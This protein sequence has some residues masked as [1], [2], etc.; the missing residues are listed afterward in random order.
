MIYDL[1]II[2]A[3]PGG[4]SAAG[5]A[6]GLG[7]KTALVEND[8][9]GGTCL[10]RGCV[11]TKLMLGAT[12]A[13]DELGAQAKVRVAE[14]QINIDFPALAKRKNKL[15]SATR[16][17]MSARL[18][19][20]GVDVFQGKG[21]LAGANTVLVESPAENAKLEFK[22]LILATGTSPAAFPGLSPD[23][24]NVLDS[25]G[26]LELEEM[27]TSLIVV[28][29]GFIGIEMAQAAHRMGTK[30]HIVDALERMAPAEDP[31]V[32]KTLQSVFKRRKWDIR[33]G[34]RVQSVSSEDNKAKMVLE[35]G[36]EI[37]A[38]KALIAVGR[39]PNTEGIGLNRFGIK[40]FG[41]GYIETD[42]YLKAADN[43]FAIGD[44]N[45]EVLLA[46]AADDQAR[47]AVNFIAGRI[48]GE[49]APGPVPSVLYGS[50]E[51]MRVGRL[52]SELE[53]GEIKAAKVALAA[54]PIAQAH[55]DTQGFVKVVCQDGVIKG[56]TAV[57][58]DV[59]RM[60]VAATMMVQ[61]GWSREKAMEFI[62]PHPTLDESMLQA[63]T[64]I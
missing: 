53:G 52:E 46:H 42:E 4:Y 64:D 37:I 59:S 44:V 5:H 54:N 47:Y 9:V 26:F 19:Q 40:T 28:G 34:V 21:S 38:D 22:N 63:I 49:Y 58:R 35:G 13:V 1:I 12:S 2:G 51:V 3:G 31:E 11:P 6:A 36:D 32:S 14:G 23:G 30:I 61:E 55:A 41:P 50:P 25:D 7:L 56:I 17:A 57:G 20:L 48:D 24:K 8:L 18:K 16:K 39:R 33:L 27:P 10:N 43:I 62:Y 29:S 60:T 15:I 45:G